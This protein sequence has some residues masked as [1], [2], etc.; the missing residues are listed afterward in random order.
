MLLVNGDDGTTT[1]EAASGTAT[2]PATG[3]EPDDFP[4]DGPIGDSAP[5]NL[6]EHRRPIQGCLDPFSFARIRTPLGS[7]TFTVTFF[8]EN[9]EIGVQVE[10][11]R[12]AHDGALLV[13]DPNTGA[14]FALPLAR[15]RCRQRAST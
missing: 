6:H 14:H 13:C 8:P 3:A 1:Y 11:D 9:Q 2:A 10:V 12:R 5:A 7:R 4:S 15:N